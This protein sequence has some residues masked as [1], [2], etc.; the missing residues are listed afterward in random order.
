ML[1]PGRILVACDVQRVIQIGDVKDLLLPTLH[2]IEFPRVLVI[3]SNPTS[4][5]GSFDK[6]PDVC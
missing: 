3:G 4:A 2:R 5:H 1:G 6:W